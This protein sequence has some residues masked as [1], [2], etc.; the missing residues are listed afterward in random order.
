M[1]LK[2]IR[3]KARKLSTITNSADYSTSDLNT[4]INIAYQELALVLVN[5]NEDFFEEQKTTFDLKQN[6]ALYSLPTDLLKFKQLR[7][8]Y[9]TPTDEDDYK[10]AEEYDPSEIQDIQTQEIDVATSNPIVDIT[11]NYMRISPVP[12]SDVTKGGEIYYIARPSA[13]SNSGDTP[14]LPTEIHPLLAV[15]G[16]KEIAMN[17][18]LYDRFNILKREW[19]EG[20]DRIKRQFAERNINRQTRFR[21]ILEVPRRR[22]KTELWG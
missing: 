12:D 19:F 17:K 5:L 20:I 14:V 22:N 11:N 13:L 1:N 7:L 2:T 4:D 15:Y 6:S 10:I 16:A 8:A 9:T 3:E 18:G 21:N